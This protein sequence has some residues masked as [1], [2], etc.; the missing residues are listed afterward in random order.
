MSFYKTANIGLSVLQNLQQAE[1]NSKLQALLNAEQIKAEHAQALSGVRDT[2]FNYSQAFEDAPKEHEKLPTVLYVASNFEAWVTEANVSTAAF[3][4]FKDKEFFT[5]AKRTALEIKGLAKD[6]LP[7]QDIQAIE[8]LAQYQS[9]IAAF[10]GAE[11]WG[12][13]RSKMKGGKWLW[14]GYHEAVL[15]FGALVSSVMVAAGV[16]PNQNHI[17]VPLVMFAVG[18]VSVALLWRRF[19]TASLKHYAEQHGGYITTRARIQDVERILGE[20]KNLA[21][22]P[23]APIGEKP[24]WKKIAADFTRKA[25]Q[26]AQ[27]LGIPEEYVFG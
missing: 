23:W 8:L 11:A 12:I 5:K 17:G 20:F 22:N 24:D 6:R 7:A 19:Q 4:G 25:R 10:G 14:N 21:A 16:D 1:T 13:I 18:T 15:V 3:D 9:K 26:E 27:R 2:L